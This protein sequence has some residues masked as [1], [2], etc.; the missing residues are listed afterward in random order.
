LRE[1]SPREVLMAQRS[2]ADTDT[3]RATN[4]PAAPYDS[5]Q[6]PESKAPQDKSTAR[7]F[8]YNL[9]IPG[10]GYLYAGYQRGWINVG[11]E[12]LSW[13]TYFYYHDLGK[14]KESDYE[15][16]ADGHWDYA[17]WIT[18]CPSCAGSTEDQLILGFRDHN[19][20]QYYEDIGKIPTYFQGWDDYNATDNDSAN[21]HFY[22]GI[23]NDSNDFLRNARYALVL[24]FV[25]RIVSAVDVLRL[26]RKKGTALELSTDTSVFIRMH[27]KPFSSDNGIGIQISKRL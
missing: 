6:P 27:T 17:K 11:V 22:R 21:R 8:L 9:A 20:Q 16:Y 12:G 13:V 18:D 2:I 25:N 1:F 5:L 3:V 4:P 24:G 23:R 15:A 19:K 7:A 26:M 14:S 10:T